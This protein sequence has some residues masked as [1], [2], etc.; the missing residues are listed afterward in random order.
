MFDGRK[1]SVTNTEGGNEKIKLQTQ[2]EG[3]KSIS[4]DLQANELTVAGNKERTFVHKTSMSKR[5]VA[6][7][8]DTGEENYKKRAN[9]FDAPLLQKEGQEQKTG[10]GG[11]QGVEGNVAPAAAPKLWLQDQSQSST[12]TPMATPRNWRSY[13]PA[14]P[15][16]LSAA[17]ISSQGPQPM[18]FD[19]GSD[20]LGGVKNAEIA[21]EAAG[22]QVQV[23]KVK[24]KNKTQNLN[25]YS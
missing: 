18:R 16:Y 14:A 8:H 9:G 10:G 1:D 2:P 11:F 25:D 23:N 5:S 15:S 12:E 3:L 17:L 7:A 13:L 21:S 4:R 19:F 6:T 20:W 24:N 22:G